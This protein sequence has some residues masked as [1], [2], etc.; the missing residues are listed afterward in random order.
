[1]NHVQFP[2]LSSGVCP[3]T[4]LRLWLLQSFNN[5]LPYKFVLLS[6]EHRFKTEIRKQGGTS[7]ET[8]EIPKE[9]GE[10]IGET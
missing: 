5:I 4:I 8:W 10:T 2:I 3:L 7:G 1:M 9:T 6:Q